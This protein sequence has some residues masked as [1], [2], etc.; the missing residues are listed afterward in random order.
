[1]RYCTFCPGDCKK[2][3]WEVE[4]SILSIVYLPYHA[5]YDYTII[6]IN[7]PTDHATLKITHPTE[8]SILPGVMLP[9]ASSTG[10]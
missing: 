4:R 9:L 1:M 8:N 2:G 10:Q 6:T 7:T 3:Q 5:Q